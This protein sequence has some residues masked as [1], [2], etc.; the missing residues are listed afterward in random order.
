MGRNKKEKLRPLVWTFVINGKLMAHGHA[1][2]EEEA[3]TNWQ[4]NIPYCAS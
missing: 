1:A 4:F 3:Q 2:R